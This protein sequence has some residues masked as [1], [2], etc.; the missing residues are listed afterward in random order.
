M[1]TD[2]AKSKLWEL[3]VTQA[4]DLERIHPGLLSEGAGV[5]VAEATWVTRRLVELLDWCQPVS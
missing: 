5:E 2:H 4:N 3:G 1:P